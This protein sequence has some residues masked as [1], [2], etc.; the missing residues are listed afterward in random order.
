LENGVALITPTHVM[1]V[2]A[3][4]DEAGSAVT[5]RL[6]GAEVMSVPAMAAPDELSS[7]EGDVVLDFTR[8]ETYE[9]SRQALLPVAE[10]VHAAKE[11]GNL[12]GPMLASNDDA[13][14]LVCVTEEVVE[15]LK[16][17]EHSAAAVPFWAANMAA[18][19]YSSVQGGTTGALVGFLVGGP[20][21]AVFGGTVGAVGTPVLVQTGIVALESDC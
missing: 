9:R 1:E 11:A 4:A 15:S 20:W 6:D 16:P 10:E 3:E 12:R 17:P 2:T 7:Q 21:G 5:F 19:G 13:W 18:L 14:W 8:A